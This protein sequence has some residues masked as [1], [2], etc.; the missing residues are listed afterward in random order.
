MQLRNSNNK[1]NKLKTQRISCDDS[2]NIRRNYKKKKHGFFHD[3][4]K[5]CCG[6]AYLW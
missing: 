3:Q 4:L 5:L 6:F 2:E 1:W